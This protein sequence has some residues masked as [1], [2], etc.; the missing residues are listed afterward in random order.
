MAQAGVAEVR[1]WSPQAFREAVPDF[2]Q[3]GRM[4]FAAGRP[5]VFGVSGAFSPVETDGPWRRG[6]RWPVAR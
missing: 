4:I 5:D 1:A 6:G 3:V 2:N